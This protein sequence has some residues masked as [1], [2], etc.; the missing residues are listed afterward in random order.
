MRVLVVDQDS[1]LLTAITQTL[2]EYFAIDAV[3]TKADAL[4]LVRVNEFEV[5]VAGERLAD[6]SGLE[7]LGQ[8]ARNRPDMLRIFSAERERLSLLKGRLGPFKLFR[9]LV[10]PIQPRQLLAAL[11]A[12]GGVENEE[13][14]AA[15][16]ESPPVA[17]GAQSAAGMRPAVSRQAA[18]GFQPAASAPFAVSAKPAA[19]AKSG[20]RVKSQ[21]PRPTLQTRTTPAAPGRHPPAK[22]SATHTTASTHNRLRVARQPTPEALATAS[23]LATVSRQKPGVGSLLIANAGRNAGLVGA[24]LVVA[25]ALLF[26]GL[27]VFN[28][29]HSHPPLTVAHLPAKPGPRYP[30]EVVKLVS[31]TETAFVHDDYKAARIDI[32]AL[33][34]LA[35]DHPQLPFFESL[36][37]KQAQAERP[38]KKR[39]PAAPPTAAPSGADARSGPPSE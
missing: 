10:Y 23:K 31:D 9:T 32:A 30:P 1:T 4:D 39:H 22:H 36:L 16:E 6:G 19:G 5:I 26:I 33:Q 18:V 20:A 11:S 27:R 2:G 25:L 28:V 24:A 38:P 7:L 3:T 34:Q 8:L 13:D 12:A 29:P 15:V 35:P 37:R 21:H 14:E 17:I